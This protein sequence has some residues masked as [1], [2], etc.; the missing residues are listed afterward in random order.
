MR[1]RST[2]GQYKRT[3]CRHYLNTHP[4]SA[5]MTYKMCDIDNEQDDLEWDFFLFSQ[6]TLLKDVPL[7]GDFKSSVKFDAL[8]YTK[9]ICDTETLLKGVMN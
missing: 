5:A 9:S 1:L 2:T 3:C 7:S 4:Y 6:R 8:N